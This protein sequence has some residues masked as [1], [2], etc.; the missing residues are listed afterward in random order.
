MKIARQTMTRV[1]LITG[2]LALCSAAW[3]AAAQPKAA[4]ENLFYMTDAEDSYE[5]FKEHVGDVSIVAPQVFFVNE[6]GVVWGQIDPRVLHL[7]RENGIDVVPLIMNPGFDQPLFHALLHD[8]DARARSIKTMVDLAAK[9]DFRGWQ[10]DFENVHIS[11]RNALTEYYKEAAAALHAAGRTISIAVVPRGSDF[12][13][14]TSYHRWIHEYWNGGYDL[15][16]L[17]EAGDFISLM[18][19]SQHTRRTPPGPVAG[20]PWMEQAV[21]FALEQGVPPEKISLGIPFFSVR[22]YPAYTAERGGHTSGTGLS[23]KDAMGLVERHRAEVQWLDEAQAPFALWANEGVYEYVFLE[24]ARSL[25]PRLK[26]VQQHGLRGISV[27]RLGQEDPAVWPVVARMLE[28][29][30]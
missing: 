9:H 22:W 20:L 2:V 27:W 13:G 5:S 14:A 8:D 25:E 11:D 6:A 7:A 29:T 16:A 21:A 4:S 23:F 26:L 19:Y 3:P 30:R 24:N 17:A 1:L 15:K 28:V 10:F 12:A 18:T